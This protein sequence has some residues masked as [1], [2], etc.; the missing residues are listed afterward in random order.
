[1]VSFKPMSLLLDATLV[2]TEVVVVIS[3]VEE[4]AWGTTKLF[5]V[6]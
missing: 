1:M 5:Q 4:E 2:H 6:A 3:I